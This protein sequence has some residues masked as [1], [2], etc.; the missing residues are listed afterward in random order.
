MLACIIFIS[1]VSE[2]RITF[3]TELRANICIVSGSMSKGE[4]PTAVRPRYDPEPALTVSACDS[5]NILK[6]WFRM[7]AALGI[8]PETMKPFG[9][10]VFDG[11][12]LEI[13]SRMFDV[14][15]DFLVGYFFGSSIFDQ[16]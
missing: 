4:L 16:E 3:L 11:P 13:L 8:L 1:P 7:Y 2:F 10:S 12:F 5:K 14:R 15:R 6:L 9:C